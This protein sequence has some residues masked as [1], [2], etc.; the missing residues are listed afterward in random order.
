VGTVENMPHWGLEGLKAEA[1]DAV[2]AHILSF[3]PAEEGEEG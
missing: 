3:R 2:T 1:V